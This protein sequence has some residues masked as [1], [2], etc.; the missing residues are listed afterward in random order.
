MKVVAHAGLWAEHLHVRF[1]LIITLGPRVKICRQCNYFRPS[2]CFL[3]CVLRRGSG[4]IPILFCVFL[5]WTFAIA[6]Y[7]VPCSHDSLSVLFSMWSPCLGK[8]GLIWFLCID[9]FILYVLLSVFFSLMSQLMRLWYLSHR[10]PAKAQSS[11]CIRA[12]SQEPSL[13]TYMNYGS[14]RR[15]QPKYQTSNTTEWLRMRVWRMNLRRTE[16]AIISWAGS[17]ILPT[18]CLRNVSF[19]SRDL[20]APRALNRIN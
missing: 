9:L 15:I 14:R 12:V 16:S 11:L 3:Y 17:F 4:V 18:F 2:G 1:V 20:Q 19:S 5:L 6:S 13:F 10:R 8:R 7:F